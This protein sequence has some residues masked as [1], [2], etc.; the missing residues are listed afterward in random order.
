[1]ISAKLF[2]TLPEDE[3]KYWHSHHW[4]VKSGALHCPHVPKLAENEVMKDILNF[5]GKTIHLW[6]IDKGHQLPLGPPQM[7]MAIT[8][9]DI[10]DWNL[11][12]LYDAKYNSIAQERREYRGSIQTPNK[13]EGADVWEKTGKAVVLEVKEVEMKK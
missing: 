3:K 11:I 8:N 2:R 4:E 1:M 9:D 7:M 5:Y 10:A 12:N 6:Q 13:E